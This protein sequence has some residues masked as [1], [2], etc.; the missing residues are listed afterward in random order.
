MIVFISKM[1]FS[2]K[3]ISKIFQKIMKK[4]ILFENSQNQ[5]S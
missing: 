2:S 5:S 3:I 1:I 4:F